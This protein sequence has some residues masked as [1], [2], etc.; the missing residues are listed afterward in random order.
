[1][2]PNPP[3]DKSISPLQFSQMEALYARGFTTYARVLMLTQSQFTAALRGTIAYPASS[4]IYGNAKKPPSPEMTPDPQP[5]SGFAPVNPGTLIDCIPP[6]YLSPLGR[7]QYL[8][9]LLH[10]KFGSKDVLE[11]VSARREGI[12]GLLA[13]KENLEVGI[14]RIDL[15]NESLEYMVNSQANHGLA[16]YNTEGMITNKGRLPL[17]QVGMFSNSKVLRKAIC[18][19]Q[20]PLIPRPRLDRSP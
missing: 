7:V 15:V 16:K 6:A 13:S 5:L 17:F 10:L 11:L 8:H 9:D 1:M 12:V 18:W 19:A 3:A 14:P 4:I 2:P 20:S